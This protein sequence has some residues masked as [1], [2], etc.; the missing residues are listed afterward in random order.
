M[1]KKTFT[2]TDLS[3]ELDL[4]TRAIRFYEDCG[5]L[6]PGRKGRTR[7]YSPRQRVRLKLILRGKRLGFS[8]KEIQ[9]VLDMY[10]ADCG[11]AGQLKFLMQKIRERRDYLHVQKQDIEATLRDVREIEE[12]CLRRLHSM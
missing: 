5:L 7:I 9:E 8:L 2:I 3:R 6:S 4:T 11:E 10:D 12:E 1:S